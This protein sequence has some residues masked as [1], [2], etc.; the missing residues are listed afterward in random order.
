MSAKKRK[1]KHNVAWLRKAVELREARA[2]AE[3]AAQRIAAV[4]RELPSAVGIALLAKPTIDVLGLGM[5]EVTGI[6]DDPTEPVFRVTGT[7][8]V[9]AL[10]QLLAGTVFTLKHDGA[11]VNLHA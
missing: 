1:T 4:E 11:K 6:E 7:F 9:A 10:K 8:T 5:L 2:A 3:A